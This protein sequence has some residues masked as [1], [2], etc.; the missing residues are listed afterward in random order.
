VPATKPASFARGRSIVSDPNRVAAVDVS[1]PFRGLASIM[2]RAVARMRR[3]GLLIPM[4]D[5]DEPAP[6][7]DRREGACLF[8]PVMFRLLSKVEARFFA[9]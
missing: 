6:R 9:V 7:F 8:V 4:I 3:L 2:H 5:S 1:T